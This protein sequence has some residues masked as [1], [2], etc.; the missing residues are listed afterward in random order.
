[1]PELHDPFTSSL[2]GTPAPSGSDGAITALIGDWATRHLSW[3][4][5]SYDAVGNLYLHVPGPGTRTMACAHVDE[6]GLVVCEVEDGFARVQPI[7]ALDPRLLHAR[8]VEVHAAEGTV[9]GTVH[10]SGRPVH[11]ATPDE[12]REAPD[13]THFFVDL[14]GGREG[15]RVGDR[16]TFA[17]GVTAAGTTLTGRALDNRAGVLA[18]LEALERLG[19]APA[20]DLWAV[21]TVQEELGG[22]G[23][24]AAV[25]RLSP[26]IALIVDAV[27]S[28]DIPGLVALD[29]PTRL[30]GGPVLVLGH[31]GLYNS[32]YLSQQV[33]DRFAGRLQPVFLGSGVSEANAI[34]QAAPQVATVHLGVPVRYLHSPFEKI[35]LE[36]L[37]A[38]AGV[39]RQI[40]GE[41]ALGG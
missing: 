3:A 10:H 13:F 18:L 22:R 36:D 27:P 21:F 32:H 2:L 26:D 38:L 16:V 24:R 23:A 39:L 4:E 29:C 11:L 40:L 34:Q 8:R 9:F 20:C 30:G 14:E 6:I 28:G 31:G 19:P 12:L 25:Q 5:I 15:V 17:A 35:H 7:G 33:R 41:G 37:L 1:M